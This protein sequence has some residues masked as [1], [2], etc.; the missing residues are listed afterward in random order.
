MKPLETWASQGLARPDTFGDKPGW[1]LLPSDAAQVAA[2]LHGLQEAGLRVALEAA[3]APSLGVPLWLDMRGLNRIRRHAPEDFIVTA[4]TGLGWGALSKA[5]SPHGQAPDLMYPQA[6]CLLPALATDRPAL[7]TGLRGYLR[8]RVLKVEIAGPDGQVTISGADVV[9]NV[10]GYDLNKLYIGGQHAYGVIT[11]VTLKLAPVAETVQGLHYGL[12]TVQEALALAESLLHSDLP[13]QVCEIVGPGRTPNESGWWVYAELAGAKPAVAESLSTLQALDSHTPRKL[14]AR[15][16]DSLRAALQAWPPEAWV[17][18]VALPR[19]ALS[20]FCQSL[21]PEASV[22]IRP[23]AGLVYLLLDNPDPVADPLAARAAETGGF[24]QWVNT[25]FYH[26]ELVRR[27][28]LPADPV[29][30]ALHQTLKSGFDPAGVLFTPLLPF[31]L[32]GP[33]PGGAHVP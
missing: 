31:D 1:T 32:P 29:V 24:L 27:H 6:E 26:P 11:A 17:A 23:A 18:E 4:E 14:P 19:G 12:D 22:Q 2:M 9:K 20:R 25:P 8:D 28:N 7:E 30:R 3:S 21:P 13:L 5:L 16:R 33:K 15:Q 10:T